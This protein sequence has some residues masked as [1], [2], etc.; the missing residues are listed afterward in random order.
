VKLGL[1]RAAGAAAVAVVWL[2]G[3][4]TAHA[5][6]GVTVAPDSPFAVG[7]AS[8]IIAVTD[9]KRDGR[10]DIVLSKPRTAGFR[11]L[12]SPT[13]GG[14]E[15][16]IVVQPG[17]PNTWT[18]GDDVIVG[19]T[20]ADVIGGGRG[21][22]VICARGGDDVVRAGDGDD[23]VYGGSG[24]DLLAPRQPSGGLGADMLVGH[25]GDDHLIGG[26]GPDRLFGNAGDDRLSGN[27]GDDVVAGGDGTD[28]CNGGPGADLTRTCE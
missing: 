22:D 6:F 3:A 5:A 19:T 13:C 11:A 28:D 7:E 14:Q 23:V 20:G 9:L 21:D 15:P 12:P 8:S 27:D 2:T 10:A 26:Q 17:V 4:G 18:A 16:T 25:S 1:G 24:D